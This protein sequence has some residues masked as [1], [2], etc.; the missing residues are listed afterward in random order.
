MDKRIESFMRNEHWAKY[1]NDAPTDICK[2]YVEFQFL[3]S[4]RTITEEEREE[5][6]KLKGKMIKADWE[7]LHKYAGNNPF[8]VYC[9]E[10]IKSFEEKA[11]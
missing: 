3:N 11:T 4:N 7:H 9:R 5:W 1:Y 2:K 6:G 8:K 10:K